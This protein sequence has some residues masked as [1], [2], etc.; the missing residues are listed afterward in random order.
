ML[1]FI[2]CLALSVAQL[3]FQTVVLPPLLIT[4]PSNLGLLIST[5]S[6][7]I[8]GSMTEL[9]WVLI[10]NHADKYFHEALFG[11]ELDKKQRDALRK[12]N[13]LDT[14]LQ[15]ATTKLSV[16]AGSLVQASS[17]KWGICLSTVICFAL[18]GLNIGSRWLGGQFHA[19]ERNWEDGIERNHFL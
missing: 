19:I 9:A 11:V 3:F 10:T 8:V 6:S 5:F 14:A 4:I 7:E 12:V 16:I 18:I 15:I 1:S 13:S 2:F 17:Q